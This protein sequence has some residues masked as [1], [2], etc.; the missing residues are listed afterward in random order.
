MLTTDLTQYENNVTNFFN[1]ICKKHFEEVN[2]IFCSP[3]NPSIKLFDKES[4][5]VHKCYCGFVFNKRQANQEA[6]SAFYTKSD[7]MKDWSNIKTSE[8][9]DQRQEMKFSKAVNYLKRMGCRSILDIGCGTGKFLALLPDNMKRV[10]FD[11][12]MESIEIAKTNYDLDVICAPM[13]WLGSE[14][15]RRETFEAISLWGVLEH[16]K[17]PIALIGD[18]KS[19]L[20]D[21]G[22]LIICVP[23]VKSSIFEHLGSECFSYCPQHL[24]YFDVESLRKILS[25]NG[26]TVELHWTIESESL[27][28][29]RHTNGANPYDETPDWFHNRFTGRSDQLFLSRHILNANKGYKIVMIAKKLKDNIIPFKRKKR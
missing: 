24:W 29:L 28:I 1:K 15:A 18:A 10:G 20:T 22:S 3:D 13:Q 6:L 19:L 5:V 7:A 21:N 27:P 2:C 16:V 25:I 4:M 11:S 17:D 12:H 14:D 26:F 9:E 8:F 23:N